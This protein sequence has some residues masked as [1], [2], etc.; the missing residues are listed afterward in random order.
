M[1]RGM[2]LIFFLA[3]VAG[4]EAGDGKL[5]VRFIFKPLEHLSTK[6]SGNVTLTGVDQV[7]A[8]EYEFSALDI[9]R[10]P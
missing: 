9:H 2:I 1:R 4:L 3:V 8:L 5:R 10:D 6:I 7:A